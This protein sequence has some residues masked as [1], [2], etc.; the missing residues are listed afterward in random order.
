MIKRQ[1]V[2][3]FSNSKFVTELTPKD[4]DEHETWKLSKK[5]C[6]IILFYCAWCP[7]C[8]STKEVWENLGKMATFFEVYSFNC[9]KYKRHV[10]KIK[11]DSPQLIKGYPTIAIYERGEP[12]EVYKG[13]RDVKSLVSACMRACKN[14]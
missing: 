9:E 1:D 8:V 3:F 4:F 14:Q 12:V 7:H 13:N 11:V 5:K 10:D 2:D 6:C